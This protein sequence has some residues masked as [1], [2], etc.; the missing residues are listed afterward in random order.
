[1]AKVHDRHPRIPCVVLGCRCGATCYPPGHEIICPKHYRLVDA[2]LKALRRRAR[3]KFKGR[4][5]QMLWR[6][7]VRQATERAA[8]LA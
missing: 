4:F 3:R 7:I 8:G 5:E 2:N 6:K 1:M